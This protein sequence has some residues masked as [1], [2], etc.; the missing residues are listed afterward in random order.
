M[1]WNKPIMRGRNG[2]PNA[3][4][5]DLGFRSSPL[6]PVDFDFFST[7]STTIV[8]DGVHQDLCCR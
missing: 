5:D 4:A 3:N 7:I 1:L 8:C 6:A 2:P